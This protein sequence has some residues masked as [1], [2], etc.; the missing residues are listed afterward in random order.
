MKK[1][2]TPIRL[3]KSLFVAALVL[4]VHSAHAEIP[5][6]L[7]ALHNKISAIGD[8]TT[9]ANANANIA[10]CKALGEDFKALADITP[11]QAS[12]AAAQIEN[13]IAIV[14]QAAQLTD[15]S[16]DGCS[17]HLAY[18]S[19]TTDLAEA[20]VK[21]KGQNA[22]FVAEIL[23]QLEHAGE[24]AQL[25]GCKADYAAFAPRLAAV[26]AAAPDTTDLSFMK[27]ILAA[28]G[29]ITSEN[30]KSSADKCNGFGE[31]L[32]AMQDLSD[33]EGNYYIA[34]IEQCSAVATEKGK[35][36]DDQG[37]DVCSHTYSFAQSLHEAIEVA[38]NRPGVFQNMLP[39]MQ[40]SLAKAVSHSAELKCSQ[41]LSGLR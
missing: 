35:F 9:S 19:K 33:V 12:Y 31:R 17:H 14:M 21:E 25:I 28:T 23:L 29:A 36:T 1:P 15:S 34:L 7:L 24:N 38:K 3:A 37:G 30:A 40:A 18:V 41:D 5:E 2:I 10:K 20:V 27:E 32:V 11:D 22:D 39:D 8:S 4:G 13:C 6:V 16:G 26:K